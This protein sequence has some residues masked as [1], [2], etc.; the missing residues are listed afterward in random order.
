MLHFC[1]DVYCI[2]ICASDI[3][4]ILVILRMCM[5]KEAHSLS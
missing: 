5:Q 2:N 4:G 1:S 3:L